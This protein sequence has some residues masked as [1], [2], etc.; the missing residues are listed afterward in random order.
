MLGVTSV[1]LVGCRPL[2][3]TISAANQRRVSAYLQISHIG[4]VSALFDEGSAS[5]EERDEEFSKLK[6]TVE[7]FA[8]D[9]FVLNSAINN[10]KVKSLTIV[11]NQ[12]NPVAW[13]MHELHV[14][15]SGSDV[16]ELWMMADNGHRQEIIQLVQAVA[17]SF[18]VEFSRK[19]RQNA[20]DRL[21]NFE[22]IRAAI[23]RD[24]KKNESIVQSLRENLGI[25]SPEQA[26]K[27]NQLTL[28][29]LREIYANERTLRGDILKSE[30]KLQQLRN[31]L[32]APVDLSDNEVRDYAQRDHLLLEL[33]R[34]WGE[35]QR[36][37]FAA[38]IVG[39][40]QE[41]AKLKALNERLSAAIEQRLS[42]AHDASKAALAEVRESLERP[43]RG[44][45]TQTQEALVLYQ[46]QL[47]PLLDQKKDLEAQ[48]AKS[49]RYSSELQRYETEGI[50]LAEHFQRLNDEILRTRYQLEAPS[51][52]TILQLPTTEN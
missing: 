25:A 39:D 26:D 34:Q 51:R 5:A 13:L 28:M 7:N 31:Q 19:A 33:T 15:P 11:A 6:Q 46:K 32:L 17:D 38:E 49:S 36:E 48:I 1:A 41:L 30:I 4:A 2:G 47:D 45:I 18:I 42:A 9:P 21:D 43:I 52:V 40:E 14:E 24:L 3:N 23:H 22:Q 35:L 12:T 44:E 29:L 16:M 20:V 8:H 27:N 37:L 50:R 10:P